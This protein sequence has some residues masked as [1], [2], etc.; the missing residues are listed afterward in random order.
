MD[1]NLAGAVANHKAMFFTE[2]DIA[3]NTIDYLAA[4]SGGLELVPTGSARDALSEDYHKMVEDGL[5]LTDAEPFEELITRCATIAE[6]A[7]R[8]IVER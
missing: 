4:V 5:L 1:K 7:N 2:K 3:G 6:D 8:I